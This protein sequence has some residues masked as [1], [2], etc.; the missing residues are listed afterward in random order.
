MDRARV[1]RSIQIREQDWF[2]SRPSR[3]FFATF[4]VKRFFLLVWIRLAL[5][6]QSRPA[7]RSYP[8]QASTGN[9]GYFANRESVK[10]SSHIINTEPRSDSIRRACWQSAH[11]PAFCLLKSSEP[12]TSPE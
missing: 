4:A 2:S 8:S 5:R 1:A 9:R 12:V 7:F 3:P 10:E 11:K 6:A